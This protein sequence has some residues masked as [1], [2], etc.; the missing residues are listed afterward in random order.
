MATSSSVGGTVKRATSGQA[1]SSS[2]GN[3]IGGD[4]NRSLTSASA[5]GGGNSPDFHHAS[6]GS[7]GG[8]VRNNNSNNK[9]MGR[10]IGPHE[11]LAYNGSAEA[12][13]E[14]NAFGSLLDFFGM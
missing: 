3:S 5:A 14:R 10:H 6:G 1:G 4:K 8:G 12:V 7:S 13:R 2:M 9:K 11:L